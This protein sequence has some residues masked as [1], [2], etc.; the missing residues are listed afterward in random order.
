MYDT[1]LMLL[2]TFAANFLMTVGINTF[3][4]GSPINWLVQLLDPLMLTE[5]NGLPFVDVWSE[6]LDAEP[7]FHLQPAA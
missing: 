2:N 7:W 6:I 1:C 4:M 5:E 3:Q